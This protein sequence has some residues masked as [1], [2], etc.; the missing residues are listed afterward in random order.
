MTSPPVAGAEDPMDTE[1]YFDLTC[2][3]C[4][5]YKLYRACNQTVARIEEEYGGF[6][7]VV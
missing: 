5:K 7:S 3:T 6:I 4:G 1:Y 2:E